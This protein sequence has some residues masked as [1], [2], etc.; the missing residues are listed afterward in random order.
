VQKLLDIALDI[1]IMA[2]IVATFLWGGHALKME[3]T[4]KPAQTST[5]AIVTMSALGH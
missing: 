1:A 3:P 4:V 2:V 5:Y